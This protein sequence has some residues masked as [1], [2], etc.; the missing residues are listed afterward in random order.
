MREWW[1]TNWD[2]VVTVVVLSAIAGVIGFYSGIAVVQ[3]DIASLRERAAA[4]EIEVG[5]L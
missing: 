5:N 1:A 2:K 4:L 3:N